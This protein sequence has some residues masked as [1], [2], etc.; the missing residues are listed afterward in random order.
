MIRRNQKFESEIES[1]N[2]VTGLFVKTTIQ[3][4]LKTAKVRLK[5]KDLSMFYGV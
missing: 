2:L 4:K 5:C 3:Y 1:N